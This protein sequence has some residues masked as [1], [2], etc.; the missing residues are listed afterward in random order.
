MPRPE[1]KP[2]DPSKPWNRNGRR[3]VFYLIS[4]GRLRKKFAKKKT[5]HLQDDPERWRWILEPMPELS[6]SRH[7][8]AR[9]YLHETIERLQQIGVLKLRFREPDEITSVDVDVAK[10]RDLLERTDWDGNWTG[11]PTD[12]RAIVREARKERR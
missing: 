9:E 5:N 7:A 1:W 12:L 11:Q 3:I 4:G 2:V 8:Y 10:A 6:G